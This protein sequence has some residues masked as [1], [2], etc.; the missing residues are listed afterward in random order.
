MKK[1]DVCVIGGG[2]IGSAVTYYLSKT[3]KSVVLL[4]RKAIGSGS[5]RA[6]F[7]LL[8]IQL[9]KYFGIIDSYLKI[10]EESIRMYETLEKELGAS[11]QHR[12]TGGLVV[13]KDEDN[14]KDR[15]EMVSSLK[16][17]NIDIDILDK[18]QTIEIVPNLKSDGVLGASYSELEGEVNPLM[19]SDAFVRGALKNKAEVVSNDPVASV[20]VKNGKIE[21][22]NTTQNCYQPKYVVNAAGMWA[23]EIAKMAGIDVP[24][25]MQRG[26]L[27]LTEPVRPLLDMVI[28]LVPPPTIDDVGNSIVLSTEIRQMINGNLLMGGTR[29]YDEANTRTTLAGIKSIAKRAASI[30][31]LN[32]N[33]NVLRA[34]SGVRHIPEDGLPIMGFDRRVDG[35]VNAVMHVGITLAPV[36]GKIISDLIDTGRPSFDISEFLIDRFYKK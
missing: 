5:A 27:I 16:K 12:R 18:K 4:E 24:L 19:L 3:N 22:V 21:A 15:A 10:T 36:A 11:I 35:W 1:V 9:F 23:N 28:Q 6:T 13:I 8:T 2:V 34:F 14:Y 26:Q 33:I 29:D 25:R 32:K 31:P 7:G 17:R 20:L 30:I